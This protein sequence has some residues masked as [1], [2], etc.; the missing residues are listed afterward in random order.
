MALFF[1]LPLSPLYTI[2]AL[3][4][5]ITSL[6]PSPFRLLRLKSVVACSRGMFEPIHPQAQ[7]AVADSSAQHNIPHVRLSPGVRGLL[8]PQRRHLLHSQDRRVA[9][10]QLRVS[11][12]LT[13]GLASK[14]L[15]H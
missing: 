15:V 10:L 11:V 9:A 5:S 6:I 1:T 12:T 14:C 4:S 13:E 3:Y 8:L 2:K 7:T